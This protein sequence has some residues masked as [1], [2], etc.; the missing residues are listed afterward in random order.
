MRR[1]L[2]RAGWAPD[3]EAKRSSNEGALAGGS[4][5]E[6]SG[7][8]SFMSASQAAAPSDSA[9]AA[10]D[11]KIVSARPT[12]RRDN[13]LSAPAVSETI[14]SPKSTPGEPTPTQRLYTSYHIGSQ[15]LGIIAAGA[16][17][18]R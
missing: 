5:A 8:E 9:I 1:P 10:R 12:R 11:S 2:S 7:V 16:M 6:T 17:P 4:A 3:N 15:K 14:R 18:Q 13:S